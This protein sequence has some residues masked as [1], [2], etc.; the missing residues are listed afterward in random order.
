MSNDFTSKKPNI[1]Q[2]H[3]PN[4]YCYK[5]TIHKGR[6]VSFHAVNKQTD[7]KGKLLNTFKESMA[8]EMEG[9]GCFKFIKENQN[10]LRLK[11]IKAVCDW[12]D[13]TKSKDWQPYCAEIAAEFTVDY[14]I[15]KYGKNI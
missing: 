2:D 6:F 9:T 12:S 8:V 15:S 3:D 10:H 1:P 7:F 5:K 13:E 11:I 4:R 14:L